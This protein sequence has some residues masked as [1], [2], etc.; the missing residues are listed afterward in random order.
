MTTAAADA[1]EG[2]AVGKAMVELLVALLLVCA[3]VALGTLP[4][5]FR[6][7]GVELPPAGAG[8]G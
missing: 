1:G 3:G 2:L 8:A 7:C 4:V 5:P 6:A